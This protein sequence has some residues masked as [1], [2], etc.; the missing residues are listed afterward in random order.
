MSFQSMYEDIRNKVNTMRE[1]FSVTLG[2]MSMGLFG[3]TSNSILERWRE[4][5]GGVIDDLHKKGDVPDILWDT[6][7]MLQSSLHGCNQ[8]NAYPIALDLLK[9]EKKYGL[10]NP[11]T[12]V[13]KTNLTNE[14]TGLREDVSAAL[15]KHYSCGV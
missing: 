6:L 12:T 14:S 11:P 10:T 8:P 2:D 9:I 13:L 1:P 3:K 15:L 7:D 4:A 5:Y